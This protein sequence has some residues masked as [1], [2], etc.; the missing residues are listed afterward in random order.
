MDTTQIVRQS[1]SEF[2][3]D[4]A[5]F[6]PTLLIA[7]ILLFAGFIFAWFF[8]VIAKRILRAV[9][10]EEI[11]AKIGLHRAFAKAGFK[12]TL[13]LL[14]SNIVYWF[15][16]I[17]FIASAVNVLGLSQ[18]S[19][20]F[21]SLIGYLPSVIAAVVIIVIGVLVSNFL[22]SIV[23]NAAESANI[24]S[25]GILTA[26]TKWSVITFAVI[27]ALVQ[28]KIAPDL[29]KILFTGLVAMITIAGGIAFGLGGKDAAKEIVDK[30]R[31]RGM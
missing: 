6:I 20:F 28:L 7:I 16:L 25:A 31:N 1:F 18:L 21:N 23:K 13:T 30:T 19:D 5:G 29:L 4:F 3:G 11:A 22:S 15:I 9:K 26:L 12:S 10:L 27:A 2:W 17:V 24:S 8:S 14:I